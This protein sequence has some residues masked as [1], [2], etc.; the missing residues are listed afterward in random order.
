MNK[1]ETKK[2][3]SKNYIYNLFYQLL[4]IVIP[5]ITT[6]YISRVI[7]AEGIGVDSV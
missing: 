7:G 3:I 4:L 1:S 5:L 2:N 6:P